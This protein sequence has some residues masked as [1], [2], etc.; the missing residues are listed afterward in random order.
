MN[1]WRRVFPRQSDKFRQRRGLELPTFVQA[2]GKRSLAI[3][4]PSIGGTAHLIAPSGFN[5]LQTLRRDL[6]TLTIH[7]QLN[8]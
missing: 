4:Q 2:L 7:Y 3:R 1:L 5:V 6:V 8:L